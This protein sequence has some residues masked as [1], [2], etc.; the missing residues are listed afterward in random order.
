MLSDCTES[1]MR[2][3]F[4]WETAFNR[5]LLAV[6]GKR[7]TAC[8]YLKLIFLNEMGYLSTLRGW[9]QSVPSELGGG[10]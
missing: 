4:Q 2:A 3:H 7:A 1:L 9:K 6:T 8:L 5:T 10:E